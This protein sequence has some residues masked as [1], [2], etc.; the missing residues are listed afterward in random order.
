MNATDLYIIAAGHGSRLGGGVPKALV[1]I[2]DEP[3]LTTTLKHVVPNFRRVF[4]ITSVLAHNAWS[5]YFSGLD[6]LNPQLR[7]RLVHLP[8]EPGVGDGHSAL[9]G[10][11][12][13][14]RLHRSSLPD[15]MVV[16]WG[17]VF[18][19]G[20][21]LI[22]ELLARP[23]K[24]AGLLPAVA[25]KNPYVCLRVNEEMQCI[26]ADFSKHGEHHAMGLH[27][28]SVFRFVRPRLLE[29]LAELHKSLW[30]HDRHLAPGGELSLLHCLH[31]LYNS[32]TPAHVYET[33]YAIRSF[34]TQEEVAQ[35]RQEARP[36]STTSTVA[37]EPPQIVEVPM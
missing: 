1:H 2:L 6:R 35:I 27:D 30:K 17:D 3:C 15:D 21:E 12:A 34:N 8:I 4:V 24:G 10:M 22:R 18:L 13:A 9:K 11:Q 29:N 25:K 33:A 31:R 32:G 23:C 16:M 19:P 26:C 14:Q 20:Q 36:S 37:D 5:T 7:E 28:Q